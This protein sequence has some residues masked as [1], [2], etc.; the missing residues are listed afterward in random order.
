LAGGLG[1]GGGDGCEGTYSGDAGARRGEPPPKRGPWG[2]ATHPV[3]EGVARQRPARDED[4]LPPAWVGALPVS[5]PRQLPPRSQFA[6]LR[7]LG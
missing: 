7:Q 6:R 5:G 3:T 1:A 4:Q 2:G